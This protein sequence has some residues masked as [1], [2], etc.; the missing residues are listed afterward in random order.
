MLARVFAVA[1]AICLVAAFTVATLLPPLTTLAEA[2]ADLD[3]PFLVWLNNFVET[4]LSDWIWVNIFVP[5]LSR[6]DWLGLAALG[7]IFAGAAVTLST[8]KGVTRSHRR[9]S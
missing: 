5:M 2:V 6:P 1:S 9:R 8:R 7:V 3:H 4:H